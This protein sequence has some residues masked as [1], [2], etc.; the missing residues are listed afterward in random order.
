MLDINYI[1]EILNAFSR[2]YV[3]NLTVDDLRVAMVREGE[4][5]DGDKFLVN[6]S[7]LVDSGCLKRLHPNKPLMDGELG[8]SRKGTELTMAL[9]NN[10]IWCKL[11]QSEHTSIESLHES[12]LHY[13]TVLAEKLVYSLIS[14]KEREVLHG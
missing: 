8:L 6:L 5:F 2:K 14:N 13:M 9:D 4:G 3:Q 11:A 7:Q 12:G 1:S 10:V